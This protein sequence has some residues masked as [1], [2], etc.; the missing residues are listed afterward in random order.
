MIGKQS[1]MS[2]AAAI[3]LLHQNIHALPQ[4]EYGT[5]NIL[6]FAH[7]SD[8]VRDLKRHVC[9]A[10]INLLAAHGHLKTD[11]D[12]TPQAPPAVGPVMGEAKIQCRACGTALV[13]VVIVDGQ[14]AVDPAM[15]IAGIASVNPQCPHKTL[16]L[17]DLRLHIQNEFDKAM[18]DDAEATS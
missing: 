16:T 3:D 1:P 9:E 13:D 6:P 12:Q 7:D 2:N 14:T 18:A 8:A 11:D 5:I 10:I 17:D 4:D 15:F